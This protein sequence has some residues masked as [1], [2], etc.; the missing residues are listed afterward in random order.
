MA[1]RGIN[2]QQGRRQLSVVVRRSGM[3]EEVE[4]VMSIKVNCDSGKEWWAHDTLAGRP[5][6][7]PTCAEEV[8]VPNPDGSDPTAEGYA[9]SSLPR[10][11]AVEV[12]ALSRVDPRDVRN[13]LRS[14]TSAPRVKVTGHIAL[15]VAELWRQLPPG[16]LTTSHMPVFGLRFLDSDQV[17]CRASVCWVGSNIRGDCGDVPFEYGFDPFVGS[18][19]AL[20]QALQRIIGGSGNAEPGVAADRPRE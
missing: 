17:V 14:S 6:L 10:V 3:D 15:R 7:C 5:M 4:C 13:T 1:F 12:I 8:T 20:Y 9:P 18:S 2:A 11:S 19:M 16:A